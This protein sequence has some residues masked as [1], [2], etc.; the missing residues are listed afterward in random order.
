MLPKGRRHGRRIRLSH[1]RA[2]VRA[3]LN[4]SL[5]NS[6]FAVDPIFRLNVPQSCQGVPT[7]LLRPRDTWPSPVDY[8]ISARRLASLFQANFK[9]HGAHV[10]EAVR[11]A[12]PRG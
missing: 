10:S 4:H 3:I 6:P 11:E 12:G 8:D 1:T 5:N 7:A 9:S 2:M